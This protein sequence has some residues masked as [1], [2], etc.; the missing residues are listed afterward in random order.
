MLR[1]GIA[2]AIKLGTLNVT[3]PQALS[4]S[5]MLKAFVTILVFSLAAAHAMAV[6]VTTKRAAGGYV[7]N[8]SGSASFTM[9]SGCNR[10]GMVFLPSQMFAV[11]TSLFY[12]HV[13]SL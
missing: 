11:L 3:T 2:E 10:P 5:Q 9:F 12:Q 8:P 13:E 7:Q 1:E 4:P 6:N